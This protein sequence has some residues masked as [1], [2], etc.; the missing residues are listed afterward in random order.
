MGQEME[1]NMAEETPIEARIDELKAELA[2]LKALTRTKTKTKMPRRRQVERLTVRRI[3][4]IVRKVLAGFH[5]DGK[6]LYFDF[7]S[8]PGANWVCR[9]KRD[10]VAH[11]MGLGSWP[12]VSLAKARELRDECLR[13]LG[14]GIDP[15]AERR[16]ARAAARAVRAKA[17]TFKQCGDAYIA[18][19]EAGW[20]NAQHAA[21]WPSSLAAHAYPMFGDLPVA[22][23][24]TALVMKA[25]QPIWTSIPETASRVRGRIEAI[26]GW[27]TTAGYRTGENPARWKGHLENL[28][29]KKSKVVRVKNHPAL[30]YTELPAFMAELGRLDGIGSL[31]LQFCILTAARTGEVLGARWDE[32]NFVEK[33][34]I[35][36][37]SRMKAGKE[38][39]VPLSDAALTILLLLKRLPS[40]PFVFAANRRRSVSS[41]TMLETLKRMGRVDLTVHGFR[42]TFA[43]WCSERTHF[44]S[45]LR[46]MALAHAIGNRVEAAY[47]RG[48]LFRKRCQLMDAWARYASGPAP[49]GKVVPLV[50]GA[51][52]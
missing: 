45:E 36:P 43:D 24:D 2:R 14:A 4:E 6:N 10:G 29:P 42:S 41:S 38:H 3:E 11:D 19:H 37:A 34:W 27:A 50:A 8:P 25:L 35:I 51:A 46:E 5:A 39:R 7:K 17:M 28:L 40:S 12:L 13:K 21:Q 9:W 20:R 33:L 31:A 32:I 23:I 44:P 16:E 22:A 30:A 26:L 52:E 1:E 47:R 49:E 18:A 15:L 48:D